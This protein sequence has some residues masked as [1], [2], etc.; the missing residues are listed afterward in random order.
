MNK[1]SALHFVAFIIEAENI[2]VFHVVFCSFL[3]GLNR[4]AY[5]ALFLNL[6]KIK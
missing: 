4:K 5:D 1:M 6:F 3:G 2:I